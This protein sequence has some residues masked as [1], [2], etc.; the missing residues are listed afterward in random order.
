MLMKPKL[1]AK[2]F[3]IHSLKLEHLTSP[4]KCQTRNIFATLKK[5]TCQDGNPGSPV[6]PPSLLGPPLWRRRQRPPFHGLALGKRGAAVA[7]AAAAA[8]RGLGPGRT[9][10][11]GE[12]YE[13]VINNLFL[14]FIALPFLHQQF[15]QIETEKCI[16]YFFT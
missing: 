14:I 1:F 16:F 12:K 9:P 11:K 8:A 10:G 7:A 2:Y 6:S 3:M 13:R 5:S 4:W 15:L